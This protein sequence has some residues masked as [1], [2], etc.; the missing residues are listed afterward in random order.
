MFKRFKMKALCAIILVDKDF[1]VLLPFIILCNNNRRW[2]NME[3]VASRV[4]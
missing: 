1:E 4:T 3:G 2:S